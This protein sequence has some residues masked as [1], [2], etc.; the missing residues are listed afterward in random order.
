MYV[1]YILI[2]CN[3]CT[4]LIACMDVRFMYRLPQVFQDKLQ[5][6]MASKAVSL[7]E[8]NFDLSNDLVRYPPVTI[9]YF[10]WYAGI[11]LN[12]PLPK[13]VTDI[14]V[15]PVHPRSRK[16]VNKSHTSHIT[17]HTST[18]TAREPESIYLQAAKSKTWTVRPTDADTPLPIISKVIKLDCHSASTYRSI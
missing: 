18:A 11:P 14:P 4:I 6:W 12:A 7:E 8:R 2:G 17:H 1:T 15:W 10:V 9:W 5:T 13:I 3:P 16:S